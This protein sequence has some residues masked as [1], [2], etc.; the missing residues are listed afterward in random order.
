MQ[1]W[2]IRWILGYRKPGGW[3]RAL[4]GEGVGVVGVELAEE[5]REAEA[6][7]PEASCRVEG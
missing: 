3:G 1:W 5:A 4:G 6:Y 7:R 2:R